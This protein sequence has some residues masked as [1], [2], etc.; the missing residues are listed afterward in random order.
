MRL[1]HGTENYPVNYREEWREKERKPR[2]RKKP[3]RVVGVQVNGEKEAH[4]KQI[5]YG[6]YECAL[7]AIS[8]ES[9]SRIYGILP[10]F[11]FR[12]TVFSWYFYTRFICAVR[13]NLN[14]II[15]LYRTILRLWQKIAFRFYLHINLANK[16][17][18][19]MNAICTKESRSQPSECCTLGVCDSMCNRAA[20]AA[21]FSYQL[22]LVN[23]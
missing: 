22:S 20:A 2:T 17:E 7:S 8:V 5:Y 19:K 4:T 11:L 23:C 15:K 9:Q 6:L 13:S 1:R 14:L 10:W 3:I 18:T 21:A 16:I 12:T